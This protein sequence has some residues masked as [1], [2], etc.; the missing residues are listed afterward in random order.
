M[1]YQHGGTVRVSPFT[2]CS[3]EMQ[4]VSENKICRERN[5]SCNCGKRRT[6]YQTDAGAWIIMLESK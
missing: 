3:K 5:Y 2:C 1:S 4:L 6:Y